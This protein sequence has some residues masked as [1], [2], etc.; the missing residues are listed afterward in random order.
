[1]DEWLDEMARLLKAWAP[2]L[3]DYHADEI[4]RELFTAWPNDT[5]RIA[6]AKFLREIPVDWKAEQRVVA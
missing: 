1:M 4:A 3:T 6:L 5:P 2:L